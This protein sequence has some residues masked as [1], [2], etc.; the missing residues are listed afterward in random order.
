MVDLV[1]SPNIRPG[2]NKYFGPSGPDENLLYDPTGP[3]G[4]DEIQTSGPPGNMNYYGN[5]SHAMGPD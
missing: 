5:N 4:P 3:S 1:S 2:P